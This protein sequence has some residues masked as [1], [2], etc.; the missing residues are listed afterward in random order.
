MEALATTPA[1]Q[2]YYV[3]TE[4]LPDGVEFA[5]WIRARF[6]Q[7][8]GQGNSELGLPSDRAS[9]EAVNDPPVANGDLTPSTS[10]IT[11][12]NRS[13]TLNPSI[14]QN[15]SDADSPTGRCGLGFRC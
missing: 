1:G 8:Q 13:I 9:D 15:D 12:R 7:G 5:Y 10:Y 4:E 3:D 6:S 14:L 2:T 11:V